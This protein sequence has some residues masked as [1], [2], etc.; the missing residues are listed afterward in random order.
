MAFATLDL[1]FRSANFGPL[2]LELRLE[3]LQLVI[4]IVL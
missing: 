2:R 1:S 4:R 3:Q